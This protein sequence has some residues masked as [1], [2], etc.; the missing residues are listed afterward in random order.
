MQEAAVTSVLA[1]IEQ[2]DKH[3]ILPVFR[4]R[5]ADVSI[6]GSAIKS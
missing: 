6:C 4:P 5:R 3:G 1:V 2:L